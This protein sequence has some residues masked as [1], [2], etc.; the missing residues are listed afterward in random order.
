MKKTMKNT[1]AQIAFFACAAALAALVG[2]KSI[3]VERHAQTLA[4][5]TDTNGVVRAVCDDAG[6]PVVLDGGWEV[7]YFQHW[8]WQKFDTLSATA[9]TGVALSINN[10]ASGADSNLVA[11]VHTSLDGLTKLV[12]TAADAYVKV[13]GGG[14]QAD[15]ALGVA[16][17][18]V[19]YF[20]DKGG[21][22]SKATVATDEAAN[23]FTISDGSTCVTCDKDG[24]CSACEDR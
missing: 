5:Y 2:C 10:Y 19:R 8:N 4:T 9:G 11:L 17:K 1:A 6:K 18:V 21:D 22:I 23:T 12:A 15:T 20:S 14:A 16:N 24:N 7:D 3:E 13:A